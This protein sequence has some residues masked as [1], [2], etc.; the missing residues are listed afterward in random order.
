TQTDR[1]ATRQYSMKCLLW[2]TIPT[3]N[4]RM[5]KRRSLLIDSRHEGV[6]KAENKRK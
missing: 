2:S 6:S 3:H 1:S 4:N 5:I